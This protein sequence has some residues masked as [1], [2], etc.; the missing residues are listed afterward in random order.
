[1]I[2]LMK[3]K[4]LTHVD[5]ILLTVIYFSSCL[6]KTMYMTGQNGTKPL[7]K[8]IALMLTFSLKRGLLVFAT[9]HV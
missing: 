3:E 7:V 5:Q 6:I 2:S 4:I 1:M 9:R 8:L